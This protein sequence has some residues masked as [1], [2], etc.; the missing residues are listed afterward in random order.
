MIDNEPIYTFVPGK[1]WVINATDPRTLWVS[2][3][4][5]YAVARVSNVP[6]G[7]ARSVSVS[8]RHDPSKILKMLQD[9]YGNNR[10]WIPNASTFPSTIDDL[11]VYRR[12]D[13]PW[14]NP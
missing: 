6:G 8:G 5:V 1:G 9:G 4:R 7:T 12:V 2:E 3:D 14:E 10:W 13:L 11:A